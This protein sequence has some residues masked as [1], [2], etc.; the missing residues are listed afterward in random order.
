MRLFLCDARRQK[1]SIVSLCEH[2]GDRRIRAKRTHKN[3]L[4]CF[5]DGNNLPIL[6]QHQH[7]VVNVVVSRFGECDYQLH[8]QRLILGAEHLR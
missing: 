5:E 4:L 6:D 1:R 3:D 8:L 7:I 2:F